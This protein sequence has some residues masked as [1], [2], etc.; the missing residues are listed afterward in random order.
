MSNPPD[1]IIGLAKQHPQETLRPCKYQ[2][3]KNETF[4]IVCDQTARECVPVCLHTGVS[5]GMGLY[6]TCE[7]V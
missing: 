7:C 2:K 1:L 3:I 6:F 4:L 5:V